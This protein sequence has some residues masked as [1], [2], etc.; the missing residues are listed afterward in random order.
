M[1][2]RCER[3]K[4]QDAVMV[5]TW[6]KPDGGI[7]RFSLCRA[8][9]IR[10]A[11]EPLEVVIEACT[12]PEDVTRDRVNFTSIINY[13]YSARELSIMAHPSYVTRINWEDF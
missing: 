5:L 1:K 9:T 6:Q 11:A 10:L 13:N 8:D 12:V 7:R 3:C 4:E 2:G